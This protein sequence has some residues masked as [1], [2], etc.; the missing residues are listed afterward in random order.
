MMI[1]LVVVIGGADAHI[2][3]DLVVVVMGGQLHD[4]AGWRW[5]LLLLDDGVGWQRVQSLA[6]VI[7]SVRSGRGRELRPRS[8]HATA[9]PHEQPLDGPCPAVSVLNFVVRTGVT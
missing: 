5:L 1:D 6:P 8:G 4:C 9:P 2:E 3:P 7:R